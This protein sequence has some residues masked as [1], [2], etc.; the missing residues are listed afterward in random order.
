MIE[1]KCV[2]REVNRPMLG[3]ASDHVARIVQPM[4]DEGSQAGWILHSFAAT[5][6]D[7]GINLVFIWQRERVQDT[8]SS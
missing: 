7:D 3:D 4:L 5:E 2:N 6:T 8:L 1:Y